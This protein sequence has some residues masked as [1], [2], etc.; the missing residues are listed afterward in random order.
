[1]PALATGASQAAVGPQSCPSDWARRAAPGDPLA[2]C[3]RAA[4]AERTLRTWA[5]RVALPEDETDRLRDQ[6]NEV[7][8][9][10]QE[11]IVK[12]GEG[13]WQNITHDTS[14]DPVIAELEPAL[15]GRAG[16]P[17]SP[18]DHDKAIA[19]GM[20]RVEKRL[21]P[22]YMDKTKEGVGAAADYLV[23][24]QIL[25]EAGRRQ[26]DVLFVTAD[27]RAETLREHAKRIASY[28]HV[29]P[30]QRQWAERWLAHSQA[31]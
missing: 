13:E 11:T 4:Q 10:V 3:Y 23:W 24:E 31:R 6:L 21:P 28:E 30:A 5:N 25:R 2:N 8:D 7:F 9:D 29:E 16:A 18:Q 1:M 14:T 20:R 22:G 19:E 15:D 17:L 26:C 27:V 12:V